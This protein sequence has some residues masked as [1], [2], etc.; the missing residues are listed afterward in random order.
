M[1]PKVIEMNNLRVLNDYLN[2]TIDVLV[3]GPRLGNGH[4]PLGY[5]PFGPAATAPMGTD[6][7]YGP[8]PYAFAG[9]PM[10]G[11]I[12]HSPYTQP[13]TTP[14]TSPYAQQSPFG[15]VPMAFGADPY[16]AQ[17]QLASTSFGAWQPWGQTAWNQ[18]PW[19]QTPWGQS[20]WGQIPW[21]P[22]PDATRQ[23]QVTQAL[24][25]KQ[26]VLEAIC[27]CAGIPV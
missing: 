16:F 19:G 23:A 21:T 2:Q 3:R 12:A 22:T 15:S 26:S 24:A 5:S 27:R 7:V 20:P 14:Y 11:P 18:S 10:F 4:S 6:V 13:Y 25:A 17:R 1:D 8:H 9:S